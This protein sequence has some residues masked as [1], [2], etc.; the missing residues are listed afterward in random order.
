MNESVAHVHK[1]PELQVSTFG[2]FQNNCRLLENSLRDASSDPRADLA[3]LW[4]WIRWVLDGH[5]SPAHEVH[6]FSVSLPRVANGFLRRSFSLFADTDVVQQIVTF[7]REYT[8]QLVLRLPT[9]T[10]LLAD[11][12]TLQTLLD[13]SHNFYLYHGVP[14]WN[15]DIQYGIDDSLAEDALTNLDVGAQVDAYRLDKKTWME[16]VILARKDDTEV[17]VAFYGM[18]PIGDRWISLDL[19]HVAPPGTKAQGRR[20]SGPIRLE[21]DEATPDTNDNELSSFSYAVLR[22][23]V[24]CS[25]YYID[26]INAFGSAGGFQKLPLFTLKPPINIAMV[27]IIVSLVANVLPWITKKLANQL[28]LQTEACLEHHIPDMEL[29][30]MI[31]QMMDTLHYSFKKICRRRY[32]RLEASQKA[33]TLMLGLCLKCLRSSVLEHRL[34][35]LKFLTDFLPMIRHATMYPFGVKLVPS[36]LSSSYSGA[37]FV[38]IS[39]PI[40][41]ST[42]TASLASWCETHNLLSLLCDSHEQLI[43]RSVDVV[44]FLCEANHFDMPQLTMI[45]DAIESTSNSIDVR[46]SLF[47]LLESIVAWLSIPVCQKLLQ[48]LQAYPTINSNVV[49]L[50]GSIAK[51]APID[52]VHCANRSTLIGEDNEE[53]NLFELHAACRFEGIQLLW[54][55]M[56]DTTDS[57]KRQLY[58]TAKIQL[59]E[60]IDA[61][62]DPPSDLDT[63]LNPIMLDCVVSLLQQCVS[64]ITRHENVPQALGIIGYLLHLFRLDHW[65]LE[66]VRFLHEQGIV[67]FV[68]EDLVAFKSQFTL[69][70]TGEFK[71]PSNDALDIINST[72]LQLGSHLDYSD[73]VKARLGLLSLLFELNPFS[74]Y[75]TEDHLLTIWQT[76]NVNAAT[77]GDR[78]MAFKWLVANAMQLSVDNVCFTFN[79][80]LSS[81]QFLKSSA[82]TPLA[83]NCILCYFRLIN[84]HEGH[85]ALTPSVNTAPCATNAFVVTAPPKGMETLWT[86]LLEATHPTVF[87]QALRFLTLLPFKSELDMEL[88]E[89]AMKYLQSAQSQSS[90]TMMVQRSL[91]ALSAILGTD[92]NSARALTTGQWTPHSLNSRGPPLQLLLSNSIKSTASFGQKVPL[93]VY[94]NDT[95]LQLQVAAATILDVSIPVQNLRFFRAGRE[96]QE[97]TRCMTLADASFKDNDTI[98]I[99]QR[100]IAANAPQITPVSTDNNKP[101]VVFDPKLFELLTSLMDTHIEAWNLL[102]RLPTPPSMMEAIRGSDW[103]TLLS[104]SRPSQL[105]YHLQVLD[106]LLF[107]GDESFQQAFAS[108]HGPACILDRFLALNSTSDATFEAYV[109]QECAIVCLRLLTCFFANG[110]TITFPKNLDWDS[111][112]WLSTDLKILTNVVLSVY[113]DVLPS[114]IS[115]M[116]LLEDWIADVDYTTL[117][118]AMLQ[119]MEFTITRNAHSLLEGLCQLYLVCSVQSPLFKSILSPTVLAGLISSRH[120]IRLLVAHVLVMLCKDGTTNTLQPSRTAEVVKLLLP[121]QG[122]SF[123]YFTLLGLFVFGSDATTFSPVALFEEYVERL[124]NE[125]SSCATFLSDGQQ[126]ALFGEPPLSPLQGIIF[127]LRCALQSFSELQTFQPQLL[128]DLW[129]SCLISYPNNSHD[130]FPKCATSS[131]RQAAFQLLFD[132]SRCPSQESILE[133]GNF[134]FILQQFPPLFATLQRTYEDW[135]WS[136]DPHAQMKS[137]TGFVGLRNLG[138]TCYL[139]S[140][141]QQLYFMPSFRNAIL[142]LPADN[143]N[144]IITQTQALF[145]HLLASEMKCIDPTPLIQCLHD[146]QGLPLN[147]MMQQDAEEFLTRFCDGVSEYMKSLSITLDCF[148]GT[149]CT[150]LIC[151]G[152]C[153][154]VRET[155]ATSFVCMTVEVKG[156]ESLAS[157][158][159]TWCAGEMLSGVNCDACGTKQDTM[160]RDCLENPP[161]TL[162]LHLKRFELNFDT[163]LREKVNDSFAFPLTLD[164]WP[165]TKAGLSGVAGECEYTLVGCVVHLGSTESGHYYSLIQDRTTGKWMEFNDDT[166]S[167]FDPRLMEAECFGGPSDT[168]LINTKS[169]YILV[170]EKQSA[171]TALSTQLPTHLA[172]DLV[173][174]NKTFVQACYA[175]EPQ[176]YSFFCS[177]LELLPP[178]ESIEHDTSLY[179]FL[180]TCVRAMHIYARSHINKPLELIP[181]LTKLLIA[182]ELN[183]SLLQIYSQHPS[184]VVEMLLYCPKVQVRTEFATFLAH[185]VTSTLPLEAQMIKNDSSS[186]FGKIVDQLFT[187]SMMDALVI[188]WRHMGEWFVFFDKVAAFDPSFTELLRRRKVGMYL[189][190]LYLGEASPLVGSVYPPFT[191]KRLPKAPQATLTPILHLVATLYKGLPP[192]ALDNETRSCLLLKTLYIRMFQCSDHASALVPLLIEWCTEWEAFTTS[193]IEVVGQVVSTLQITTSSNLLSLWLV[194]DPFLSLADSLQSNRI[195]QCLTLVW[196]SIQQ[197]RGLQ[198]QAQC[199]GLLLALGSVHECVEK[200]LQATVGVFGPWTGP[201]IGMVH[202]QP[203]SFT[204]PIANSPEKLEWSHAQSY[205]YLSELL[206]NANLGT[207][208]LQTPPEDASLHNLVDDTDSTTAFMWDT[209]ID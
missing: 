172:M 123:E 84:H 41:E 12:E 19:K 207:E 146:E 38:L 16:G 128:L 72:L 74:P 56:R 130:W 100:P 137:A 131:S 189:L 27:S 134:D 115:P 175:H 106:G 205:S 112:L 4:T 114:T 127:V 101:A 118:N 204:A 25:R 141:L 40:T 1:V 162:M 196:R 119:W 199:V 86:I 116:P 121:M 186:L 85:I 14:V 20:G 8:K 82:L 15:T 24:P 47:F 113:K 70:I 36:S 206:T 33:D 190:D 65:K 67:H 124:Q 169:A 73:H 165:Y 200:Q 164:M 93:V 122:H 102:L 209:S 157:S 139:N 197:H 49:S 185:L 192:L 202:Q 179:S 23:R 198:A 160:K 46:A 170:Y 63:Q 44:R 117:H 22:P 7:L 136:Y 77:T 107:S 191:R 35:G 133:N 57:A 59:H 184:H 91:L 173:K 83:L 13:P 187:F 30:S 120:S 69:T 64:T 155:T 176:L 203:W 71:D 158:L 58:E 62:V 28:V 98:L 6:L 76:L 105:L 108:T 78:S 88:G 195:E 52:P 11:M 10:Q 80:L 156:H 53:S 79:E 3:K 161:E 45:W 50:I 89:T 60:A 178:R 148:Q 111:E 95:V 188:N 163:F 135:E 171:R 42:T 39:I 96:I 81:H 109:Q 174:E 138:C 29:R 144:D 94:A 129:Q 90:S 181:L 37:S 2:D 140:T 180:H 132:L 97:L 142:S 18:E 168:M 194:L 87:G 26:I 193:V 104:S 5:G 43:R 166:V 183:Q 92:I 54:D 149:L 145:A 167:F 99:S 126:I 75:L 208:W 17:Y 68:L 66:I 151:Q 154:S 143:K 110:A 32:T 103:P 51:H 55:L 48:L 21:L 34:H 61:N 182:P 9:T 150:Q 152:G 159:Q 125:P 147:V 177:L 201:L 31:K 153:G